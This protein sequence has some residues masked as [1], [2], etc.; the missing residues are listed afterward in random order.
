MRA[1]SY[2][3]VAVRELSNCLRGLSGGWPCETS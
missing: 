1:P 3:I 2:A